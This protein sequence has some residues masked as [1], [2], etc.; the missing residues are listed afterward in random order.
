MVM[1]GHEVIVN[2]FFIFIVV[3]SGYVSFQCSTPSKSTGINH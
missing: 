1:H 2:V 3:A